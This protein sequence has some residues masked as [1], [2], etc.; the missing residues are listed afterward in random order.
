MN[1]TIWKHI[2]N[3]CFLLRTFATGLF[4]FCFYLL[5]ITFGVTMAFTII[6][7]PILYY[8]LR[9]ADRFVQYERVLTKVYTDISIR[10]LPTRT[11][12]EGGIWEQVRA[13]LLDT[14]NWK[15][16]CW[17]MLRFVVGIISL[18]CA[19]LFYV[20]PIIFMLAPVLY[21]LDHFAISFFGIQIRTFGDSILSMIAGAVFTWIGLYLGNVLVKMIGGNTRRM[22]KSLV[23]K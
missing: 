1:Q 10:T 7:I 8:V 6:G 19:A 23:R 17:L 20:T 16:I 4:Y 5:G 12:V 3:F 18:V 22:V 11:R 21:R 15:M 13:D 2:R 9:S 14:H